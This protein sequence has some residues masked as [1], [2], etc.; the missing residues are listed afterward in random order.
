VVE[1][2]SRRKSGSKEG[3]L[4][5]LLELKDEEEKQTNKEIYKATKT[6]SKLA[7]TTTKMMAFE[8]LYM[9]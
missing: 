2:R 9:N 3:Y 5:K 7:V 8:L 6:E 4:C 1:W